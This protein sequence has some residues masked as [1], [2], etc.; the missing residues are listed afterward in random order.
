MCWQIPYDGEKPNLRINEWYDAATDG[1]EDI[2]FALII[3]NHQW[4][5]NG[6]NKLFR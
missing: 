4:G 5:S 3:A 6:S 2:A 1:D